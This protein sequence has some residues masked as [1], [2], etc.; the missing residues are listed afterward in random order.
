LSL[1]GVLN[2]TT[3]TISC[4]IPINTS[5]GTAYRTKIVASMPNFEGAANNTN[6]TINMAVNTFT[7]TGDLIVN[8]NLDLNNPPTASFPCFAGG[9]I[10]LG[11]FNLRVNGA[12]TGFDNNHFVVTNGTGS[13]CINNPASQNNVY[14]VAN[15]SISTNFISINNTGTPDVFCVNLQPQ[16]LINGTSGAVVNSSV[17]KNTWNITEGVLGGSNASITVFWNLADELQNFNRN[18][19]Y[20]SHYT[21]NVYDV[22]TNSSAVGTNPYSIVRNNINSFSPFVVTSNASVLPVSLL[23]FSGKIDSDVSFLNWQTINEQNSKNF[24]VQRSLNAL[25]FID[26]ATFNAGGF[27][28]DIKSYIY[29]DEVANVLGTSFY[30]R[31]Q[32]NDLDGKFTYSPMIL[33]KKATKTNS[34]IIYPN[35]VYSKLNA[36]A[37]FEKNGVAVVNILA[38]DGKVILQK[39]VTVQ[40]GNN[41]IS[42]DVNTIVSGIYFIKIENETN[43][44][45]QKFVKE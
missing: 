17:V 24:I 43:R 18:G 16:V 4:S 11:N 41:I 42:L 3:G 33:L 38:V 19:C 6:L 45:I 29:K 32:Q 14:P 34:L 5:A 44:Y 39:N 25:D 15:N 10:I 26:N 2:N 30:Y 21:G 22:Q 27:S 20:I 36:Q 8:A 9:K 40:K 7:L 28:T 35:P 37:Y 31:L 13:L 1:N 12:I 23:N